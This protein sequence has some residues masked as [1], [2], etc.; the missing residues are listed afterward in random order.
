MKFPR[1]FIALEN[2]CIAVVKQALGMRKEPGPE[3][4][5]RP[6]VK[7]EG[8]VW[9]SA[10]LSYH[11][12][13]EPIPKGPKNLKEGL[14][15]HTC[16]NGWCI[17]PDH[18]YLGTNSQNSMDKSQRNIEWRQSVGKWAKG[19]KNRVGFKDPEETRI[20]KSRA[21]LGNKRRLGCKDSEEVRLKKSEGMKLSWEKRKASRMAI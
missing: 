11:L 6:H 20:K 15:L 18:L 7:F 2:G 21:L 10:R 16:D 1:E 13:C 17:N 9:K 12:N 5:R 4:N 8:E 14:V 3:T 19:N